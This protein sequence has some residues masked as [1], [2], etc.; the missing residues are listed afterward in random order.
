MFSPKGDMA[1]KMDVLKQIIE[2]H[3]KLSCDNRFQRALTACTGVFK[4]ITL[5]GS[6]QG[7]YFENVSACAQ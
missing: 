1:D 2:S 5:V 7:N 4:V 3:L 6:I